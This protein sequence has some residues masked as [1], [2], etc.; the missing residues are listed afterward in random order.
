MGKGLV[1]GICFL[2]I[3]G[4]GCTP[5][6]VQRRIEEDTERRDEVNRR[7][8][9]AEDYYAKGVMNNLR[10]N[11]AEARAAFDSALSVISEI[12]IMTTPEDKEVQMRVNTLLREIAYDYRFTLVATGGVDADNAPAILAWALEE[13]LESKE[14]KEL[15][16]KL[17]EMPVEIKYDFPIVWNDEVKEKIIY[18]QTEIRKPF[19]KW[20]S[21]SGRYLPMIKEIFRRYGLPEDLAYLPL[22]ESGYEPHAYSWA[23][24]VGIWQFIAST[25][26][27]FGL[28]I[29]WWL[30]ERRDP[31]KSTEA[32]AKY[33]KKLYEQ[34]GDWYLALA[35]Y[36]CGEIRVE[37]SIAKAGTRSFW[38]LPLPRQTKNYVPLFIA[39]LIIAKNPVPFG[40]SSEFEPPI[41]YERVEIEGGVDLRVVAECADTSF[42]YIRFL[43][44]QLLRWCTPPGKS[45]CEVRIPAGKGAVFADRFAKLPEEK[46]RVAFV[47]HKVKRGE[48]LSAIAHKYGVSAEAI[49]TANQLG[50]YRTLRIGQRLV[51]PVRGVSGGLTD[52]QAKGKPEPS[53]KSPQR[54]HIVK[55]GET[56]SEIASKYN[57]PLVSLLKYNN[58][59]KNSTI[60]PGDK[61]LLYEPV[62]GASNQSA[63][64]EKIEHTVK[65]GDSLY[66]ISRLYGVK[67]DDI[68]AW[69]DLPDRNVP[70]RVGQK[71]TILKQARRATTNK[72]RVVYRVKK[73]DTLFSIAKHYNVS[74]ADLRSWNGI[75]GDRLNIG[76]TLV[77]YLDNTTKNKITVYIVKPGDT[78]W[79]IAGEFG[80]SVEELVR[81][82]RLSDPNELRVGDPIT[83]YINE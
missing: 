36:N 77:L 25:G 18:F 40:F 56:L 11:W 50:N 66:K 60:R 45:K 5:F 48:T 23:H 72:E 62:S 32:S 8:C 79:S 70:L 9:V 61:I 53:Q 10:R 59:T 29:N 6:S 65:K 76:Q 63:R 41:E 35:A 83:V 46:K 30:D 58:L 51:I 1:L 55:P 74:I 20:L 73:G 33:L 12:D 80:V 78:L 16:K 27:L 19:Q 68:V 54:V 22:V 43:N 44:P 24:A 17:S 13:S 69:N 7:L 57:I 75:D 34:F 38:D 14:L 64:E 28:E 4:S 3:I 37:K 31:V 81:V 49:V 42:E 2:A 52:T 15:A 39:A 47:E 26:K 82:N 21:N 67:V 71:L